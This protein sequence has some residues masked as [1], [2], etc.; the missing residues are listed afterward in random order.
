MKSRILG[1]IIYYIHLLLLLFVFIGNFILP[2]KYLPYFAI[3]I[4]IVMLDWNDF[5]NMCILTKLE[6]YAR[7]GQWIS[8]PSTEEN[9]P[10]FFRPI[11]KK[12]TG[13]NMTRK[14]A[15]NLNNFLF[16]LVLLITLIRIFIKARKCIVK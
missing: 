4:I 10:E 14:T 5:D 15:S 9:A 12:L 8:I 13:I 16:L 7:T 2:I 3:M 1:D 11:I 6:H